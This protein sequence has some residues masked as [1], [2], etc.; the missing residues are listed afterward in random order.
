MC[1]LNFNFNSIKVRLKRSVNGE[2]FFFS[3][4]QFHK[5]TIKTSAVFSLALACSYFN[6]IKVR[7]KLV[8]AAI[9]GVV[10]GFQFHK[11]TIKTF[12]SWCASML[13]GDFNS[14]KVRLKRKGNDPHGLLFPL[15][16]FHKGTI[17]T[18][19]KWLYIRVN[20]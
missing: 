18:D 13:P 15:F 3:Q 11:G 4:F 14:I 20:F 9:S 1:A 19:D 12:R 7:L 8:V 17:K 5:G 6:S 16:Q 10:L 2:A